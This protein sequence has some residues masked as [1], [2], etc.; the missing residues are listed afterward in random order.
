M[1]PRSSAQGQEDYKTTVAEA[2]LNDQTFVRLTLS[3]QMSSQAP[4]WVK[5]SIRPVLIRSRRHWQFSYFDATRNV[6]ANFTR[7][8]LR[9]PL[10]EALDMSFAHIEVQSTGGDLHIRRTR[11]G[12]VLM[13]RGKPQPRPVA[14]DLTHDRSKDYLLPP[15]EHGAFLRAIGITDSRGQ[16]RPTM[17]GKFAQVN[18]FLRIVDQTLAD[19]PAD[20]P[21]FMVDCGCGSA[22]LTFA[23]YHFLRNVRD[24]DV[25]V[26]GIDVKADLIHKCEALRDELGWQGLEFSAGAIAD[27]QPPGPVEVVLSL[28]ACDTA[29]DEAI[30]RGVRWASR[31]IL[32]AP[33]C[34]HELHHQLAA[35]AFRPL[36]RHGILRERLADLLTDTFRALALRIMGYRTA[37][38]EF[39]SPEH[40]AKNLLI[41]AEAGLKPGQGEFVREYVALRDFWRVR[42]TIE[43]LLGEDFHR[44]LQ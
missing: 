21:T 39:V 15:A 13:T 31:V 33:C 34:Q 35:E 42:P 24:R 16:V 43:Q 14:V 30:A 18:E 41:R 3:G 37:V 8:R 44:L 22:H 7:S 9:R 6:V 2:V 40:T 26:A 20:A 12:K 28:H 1:S 36:L 19:C 23:A 38:V 27:Y 11:K 4:P 10:D 17:Q 25:R 5:I 29:T 32:A